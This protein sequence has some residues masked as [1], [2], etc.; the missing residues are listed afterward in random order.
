MSYRLN[1]NDGTWH[2]SALLSISRVERR[3]FTLSVFLSFSS[4]SNDDDDDDDDDD[5]DDDNEDIFVAVRAILSLLDITKIIFL[6]GTAY[7]DTFYFD[8]L[9]DVYEY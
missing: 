1:L 7:L 8:L 5:N 4:N 2:T 9:I 6:S 3:R